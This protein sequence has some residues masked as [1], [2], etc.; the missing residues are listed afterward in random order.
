MIAIKI[1]SLIICKDN[2]YHLGITSL[3]GRCLHVYMFMFFSLK[4][5]QKKANSKIMIMIRNTSK[6]SWPVSY[7]VDTKIVFNSIHSKI[8]TWQLK[9]S[10]I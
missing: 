5:Q 6:V 9:L 1:T 2:N 7:S 3:V 10:D 8:I 4:Q